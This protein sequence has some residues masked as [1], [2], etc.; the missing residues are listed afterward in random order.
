MGMTVTLSGMHCRTLVDTGACVTILHK[1][2]FDKL[3]RCTGRTRLLKPTCFVYSVCGQKMDVLGKT[4]IKIDNAEVIEV[5][6]VR[7]I[8]HDMILG[9]DA[10]MKGKG[11]IDY[12]KKTL[13]WFHKSWPLTDYQEVDHVAEIVKTPRTVGMEPIDKVLAEY[14]D[15]FSDKEDPHGCCDTEAITIDTEGHPPIL[16][17]A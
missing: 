5:M 12:P 8:S 13:T 15:V 4:Q 2:V 6:I 3:C 11:I 10:L 14:C 16:Q 7:G 9:N 1:R 17:R